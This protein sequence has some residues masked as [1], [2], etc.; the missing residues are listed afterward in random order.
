MRRLSLAGAVILSLSLMTSPTSGQA[1]GGPVV[2]M[3]IDAEDGG[4]GGHGPITV[5]DDV[6]NNIRSNVTNGGA[7]IL[8]IGGGKDLVP[9]VDDVTEFWQQIGTDLGITVTFVNGA[10]AIAAVNFAGLAILGVASSEPG[11]LSGGLTDAEND[12]LAARRSDIASFVN[13]GGG[14]LGFSQSG[15]TNLYGY[16]T[17]FGTFQVQNNQTYADIE[18]TADGLALGITNALDVTAWHDLY[19]VFPP[20]L[21]IL[22]RNDEAG[23]PGFGQP[24]AIGGA[25]VV[26]GPQPTPSPPPSPTPTPTSTPTPTP[27]P[28]PIPTTAPTPAEPPPAEPLPV[29]P[30]FTG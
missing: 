8:A 29:Q 13:G 23:D 1:T 2:L 25:R 16:L 27:I 18:P 10:A 12:A 30:T 4:V 28:T 14:L 22:A 15:L 20:F 26:I 19:L 5:Y 9:P 7:G 21:G 6:V 11:T 24:A 17:G 3:G